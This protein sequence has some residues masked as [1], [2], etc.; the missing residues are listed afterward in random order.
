MNSC[1]ETFALY[2]NRLCT[3]TL[4]PYYNKAKRSTSSLGCPCELFPKTATYFELTDA[5]HSKDCMEK[6]PKPLGFPPAC[7][8]LSVLHLPHPATF[9]SLDHYLV[10]MTEVPTDS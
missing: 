10:N 7:L 8:L 5:L 2:V 9:E 3:H 1:Y 6:N 4:L